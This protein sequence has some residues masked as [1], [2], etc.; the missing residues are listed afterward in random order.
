M[1]HRSLAR[2]LEI[3]TLR[4]PRPL[5]NGRLLPRGPLR[6][7]PAALARADVV[8]LAHAR[9]AADLAEARAAIR[10]AAPQDPPVYSWKPRLRLHG[11]KGAA[12]ARV[13]AF[14]GIAWPESF[15]R[16]LEEA[17]YEVAWLAAFPDH[18]RWR[19][20]ELQAL[21]ERAAREGDL[22]LVTTE[23]DA[24]RLRGPAWDRLSERVVV[25]EM[26]IVWHE[27]EAREAL[28]VLLRASRDRWRE[29]VGVAVEGRAPRP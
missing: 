8:I 16:S 27:A 26:A 11:L 10:R 12:P 22:L 3:V 25:A 1:Q 17:G 6:E 19:E 23:K 9:D 15:R 20:R 4:V 18:H 24:A 28:R 29:R 7:P 2:E 21:I 13:A 14:A 5:G